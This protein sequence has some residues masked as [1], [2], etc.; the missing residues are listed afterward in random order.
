VSEEAKEKYD[1]GEL[2]FVDVRDAPD[3]ESVHIEGSINLGISKLNKNLNLIPKDKEVAVLCY[4]GG[5]SQAA[6]KTLLKKGYN[7][8]NL[9]GGMIRWALY[10]NTDFLELL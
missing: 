10:I 3:F 9:K 8:K 2:F 5:L 6:V 1:K 7:A 4:G